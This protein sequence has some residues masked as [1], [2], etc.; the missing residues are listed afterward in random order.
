MFGTIWEDNQKYQLS[1]IGTTK[2]LREPKKTSIVQRMF[3]QKTEILR[4][5]I[6]RNIFIYKYICEYICDG[7]DGSKL[8]TIV[9]W[10]TYRGFFFL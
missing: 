3:I 8:L 1:I 10:H 4:L 7:Y 2:H 5:R 9:K 6:R